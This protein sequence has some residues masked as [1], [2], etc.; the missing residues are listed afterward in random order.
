[1]GPSAKEN[2]GIPQLKGENFA[3]WQFRVK[4]HME[5]AEVS[6]ALEEDVPGADPERKR[7]LQMDRKAKSLLVSFISDEC[8]EIVRE[9]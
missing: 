8:L 6:E 3:N 4:L 7:F 9:K 1:M 2:Y 5:A